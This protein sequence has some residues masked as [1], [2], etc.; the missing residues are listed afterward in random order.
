[1]MTM[2]HLAKQHWLCRSMLALVQH[3]CAPS[4]FLLAHGAE[5]GSSQVPTLMGPISNL[6]IYF[7]EIVRPYS[8]HPA[9]IYRAPPRA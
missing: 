1:M 8:K 9:A 3:S 6:L 5:V 2:T 7:D 4:F